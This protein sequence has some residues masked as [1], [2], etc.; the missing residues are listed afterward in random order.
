[1]N[2]EKYYF[3]GLWIFQLYGWMCTSNESQ[4]CCDTGHRRSVGRVILPTIHSEA[5]DRI[6]QSP[7]LGNP[8]GT[9]RCLSANDL[10]DYLRV[11][12]DFGKWKVFRKKLKEK[13]KKRSE[14][15]EANH[16]KCRR[17]LL[18]Q[19]SMQTQ[20]RRFP[21]WGEAPP[22]RLDITTQ[23]QRTGDDQQC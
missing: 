2:V 7:Y 10:C 14:Y 13:K 23:V 3:P 6:I 16:N 11:R 20:R 19:E 17:F 8:S 5:P 4:S 1:M 15:V 22:R 18:E 9:L 21:E 12:S